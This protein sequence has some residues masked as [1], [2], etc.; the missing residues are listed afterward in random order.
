M[1]E[2]ASHPWAHHCPQGMGA[3]C[4][5]SAV[6]PG[7]IL[8]QVRA[9]SRSAPAGWETTAS[10][11]ENMGNVTIIHQINSKSLDRRGPASCGRPGWGFCWGSFLPT[12]FLPSKPGRWSEHGITTGQSVPRTRSCGTAAQTEARPWCCL[13]GCQGGL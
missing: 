9:G 12:L 11:L 13:A 7:A 3:R 1:R 2:G 6:S 8:L 5:G 10:A 4:C